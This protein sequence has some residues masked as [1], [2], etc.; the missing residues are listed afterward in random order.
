MLSKTRNNTWILNENF[1]EELLLTN[2]LHTNEFQKG[3]KRCLSIPADMCGV[4][5]VVPD[6][7][8]Q[9]IT[10][11]KVTSKSDYHNGEARKME[12]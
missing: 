1:S 2:Y 10:L 4:A 6:V 11:N 9:A 5:S 8:I 12:L 3:W 7:I